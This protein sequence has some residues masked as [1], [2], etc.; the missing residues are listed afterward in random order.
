[1]NNDNNE[2]KNDISLNF[3]NEKTKF[4]AETDDED[5]ANITPN[6]TPYGKQDKKFNNISKNNNEIIK[7]ENDNEK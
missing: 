6:Y 2:F 7:N 5:F 1:M 4:G 3:L